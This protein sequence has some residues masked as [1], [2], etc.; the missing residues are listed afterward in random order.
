LKKVLR[1]RKQI[2]ELEHECRELEKDI[3]TGLQ[4]FPKEIA[5]GIAKRYVE[6]SEQLSK[7]YY[8]LEKLES[9]IEYLYGGF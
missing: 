3:S 7:L 4:F 9:K 1:L 5:K 2:V 6:V 8:E